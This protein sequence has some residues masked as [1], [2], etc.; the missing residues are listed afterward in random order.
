M[1]LSGLLLSFLLVGAHVPTAAMVQDDQQK[2]APE[3]Q[4]PPPTAEPEKAKTPSAES[5]EHPP[6]AR[7]K[8][9]APGVKHPG[10]KDDVEAIGNRKITG[11]DI[12]PMETD[13]K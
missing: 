3:T 4:Q 2:S 6:V 7:Q 12:Y 9:A 8:A 1:K 10:G 11:F 13:I 5:D